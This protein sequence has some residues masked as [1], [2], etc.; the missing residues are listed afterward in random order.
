MEAGYERF[1][2]KTG[3]FTDDEFRSDFNKLDTLLGQAMVD[4]IQDK[5]GLTVSDK[6]RDN[7]LRLLPN[8]DQSESNFVENLKLFSRGIDRNEKWQLDTFGFDSIDKLRSSG[9]LSSPNTQDTT[10]NTT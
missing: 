3:L 6:E 10:P 9:G 8:L 4:Y 1:K 5:S 2:T 7:L